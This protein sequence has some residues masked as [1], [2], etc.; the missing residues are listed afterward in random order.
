[1]LFSLDLS[2]ECVKRALELGVDTIVTHHPAIYNPIKCLNEDGETAAVLLAAKSNLNVVSMH[3]NL[4]MAKEGIDYYLAQG[5]G[6][7]DDKILYF[8][9]DV[10]GYGR[11]FALSE[12]SLLECVLE[13]AIEVF[14]SK[15]ILVYGEGKVKN[16]ASFCG[17][18]SDYALKSVLSGETAA[19]LIISSDM[20]HHVLKELI[21][22]DKKVM[23]LP[24]YVSEQYGF[25][26]FY[27]FV[28][29]AV[30]DQVSA[31]YFLDKRFM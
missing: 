5:L 9:T 21:E 4:D 27:A 7:K 15:K 2:I 16:V 23:I 19:D 11:E 22:R 20:P 30:N 31:Y 28:K 14:G 24:H 3:L 29:K 8:T 13:R 12:E 17:G 26:K 10:E 1:M 18:G 6:A 25:E